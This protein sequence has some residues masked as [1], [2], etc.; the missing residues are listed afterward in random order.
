MDSDTGSF[1]ECPEWQDI[2]VTCYGGGD[3][4]PWRSSVTVSKEDTVAGL[5][6]HIFNKAEDEGFSMEG[7]DLQSTTVCFLDD[8]D[9]KTYV[10]LDDIHL[11]DFDSTPKFAFLP[12][13]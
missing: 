6:D 7:I 13:F 11:K 4:F 10:Y 12:D 9:N 3:K 8:G 2:T 1:S 5:K